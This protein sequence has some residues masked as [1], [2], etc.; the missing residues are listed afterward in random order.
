MQNAR[1]QE[2]QLFNEYVLITCCNSHSLIQ[3]WCGQGPC[4]SGA[5]RNGGHNQVHQKE[6]QQV[7]L[8]NSLGRGAGS[9]Q[10]VV[11]DPE[12]GAFRK[13]L[14]EGSGHKG[15]STMSVMSGRALQAEG[16]ARLATPK[17]RVR[18]EQG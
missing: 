7:S 10:G 12:W 17:F 9:E 18:G 2:I 15:G 5:H 6:F 16:T 3:F 11:Q 8:M 1:R 14:G 13:V 4:L